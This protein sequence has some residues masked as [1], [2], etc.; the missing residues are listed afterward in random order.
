MKTMTLAEL[1]KLRKLVQP[2]SADA[3]RASLAE[4]FLLP[5]FSVLDARQGYWQK[6]KKMWLA[7]GIQSEL[8][9]GDTESTSARV[10][11]D[12][13]ATY[14]TIGGRKANAAPGGGVLPLVKGSSGYV[15]RGPANATVNG[16]PVTATNQP[17]NGKTVRGDG[18]GRPL[19]LGAVPANRE[20]TQESL[21]HYRR[22][23]KANSKAFNIGMEANKDNN[24][25]VEDNQGSGTSIFDPV[26]CELAYRWFC[27]QGGHVLDPFAG[28]SVRGIV[29]TKLG[30]AYSGMDLR[31][32]QADAN[33]EQAEKLCQDCA[34]N[35]TWQVG[36]SRD[37]KQLLPGEYDLVFSCPPYADLERYSDDPR[38]LSTM[39][40]EVFVETYR[41][42]VAESCAML[43]DNRF[44]CF[45][46][47]DVRARDTGFYRNFVGDTVDAFRAAGLELY[48][49]MILV[50]AV[51]SLP[52]RIGRQF[53]GYRKVGKTHQNVLVFVKGDPA[54]ASEACGE[55]D[56]DDLEMPEPS[57][58]A[59][60]VCA[61]DCADPIFHKYLSDDDGGLEVVVIGDT[62][63]AC[64][65]CDIMRG[66]ARASGMSAPRAWVGT[67]NGWS[68]IEDGVELTY[69]IGDMPYL[70]RVVFPDARMPGAAPPPPK[71]LR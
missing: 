43:K 30:R 50:T 36:D 66:E 49:E 52:I 7:L 54:L 56:I 59:I 17:K 60:A 47:G 5:P 9:R 10:G 63:E 68:R 2:P 42:I 13:E 40:Y 69:L 12:D 25:Q 41:H 3:G 45:V 67:T 55:I 15:P 32:E 11:P 46:V 70:N 51:G 27:P 16:S 1:V 20:A 28:G 29:A 48:N 53:A 23:K 22:S 21:D 8:G 71:K 26:L 34:A 57:V 65:T 44:A 61:Q 58:G 37:I 39:P 4:R 6:R 33:Y 62:V 38:D 35:L 24:W 64:L 19:G 14:R 31:A 18:R